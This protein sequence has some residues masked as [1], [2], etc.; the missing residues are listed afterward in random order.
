MK[1]QEFK[2]NEY[3]TLKLEDG[4]INI[5]VNGELF[6]QCKYILMRKT[7]YEFEDFFEEIESVDELFEHL[8]HSL[9]VIEPELIDI[10]FINFRYE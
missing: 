6:N 3:I 10:N 4:E 1:M 7:V 8:D 5:Y 2:V 9:E